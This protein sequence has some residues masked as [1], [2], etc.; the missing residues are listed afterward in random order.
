MFLI[1]EKPADAYYLAVLYETDESI[2]RTYSKKKVI[3]FQNNFAI[4]I[5]KHLC[6][7]HFLMT[8]QVFRPKENPLLRFSCEYREI[9]RTP[10][11]KIICVRLLLN[12]F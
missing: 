4:F 8:L 2:H 3:H 6:W 10:S 7:S 1:K 12:L 5:G 11:L 9:L